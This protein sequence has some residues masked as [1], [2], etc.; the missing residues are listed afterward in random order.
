MIDTQ[1]MYSL[2]KAIPDHARVILVGDIH[3]LPSVGPGNVLKD[4]IASKTVPLTTLNVIFRQATGSKIITNAH[5]INQGLYPDIW[6]TN[7]S[8]FFFIEAEEGEDVLKQIISLSVQRLPKKYGFHPLKEIQVFAPMKKGIIGTENLNSALQEI[9]NPK[10]NPILRNGHKY[11]PGDKVMQIRNNYDK[12]VYNGDI[13]RIVEIDHMEKEL[14]VDFDGHIVDYE[15]SD[16]D[17]LVLAYAVSVHKY[18]GS[19]CPC[20]VMPVHTS[21]FKLLHRNLLYTGVTRGKKLVVLVGYK[22]SVSPS[23]G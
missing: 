3:Q 17:E 10:E 18:Q 7:G 8:D 21:H 11:L 20:I 15:F 12:Q 6:N 16:L 23:S 22:K 9:L 19:E 13:G 14:S 4:I 5:R 2:L 1:L